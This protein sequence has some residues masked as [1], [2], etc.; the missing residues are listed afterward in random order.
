MRAA[1]R[2]KVTAARLRSAST[3]NKAAIAS[4]A[5]AI[6]RLCAPASSPRRLRCWSPSAGFPAPANR[7]SRARWRPSSGQ[8]PA[9]WCCAPTSSA[10]RCSAGTSTRSCPQDAYA[11]AVTAR[12][13]ATIVDKARRAVAAGHAPIVDARVREAGGA[14]RWWSSPPR[15]AGRSLSRPFPRRRPRH[16]PRA[17]RR[18]RAATPPTPTRR[19]RAQQESY[20]LGALDWAGVDASGTPEQTLARARGAIE[21]SAGL[22]APHR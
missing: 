11:P 3:G 4:D 5:R 1:I 15:C 19:W 13:Y 18:A 8:R 17:R 16:P 6:F 7:R 21:R 22:R 20:D 10:R 14:A 2:A 12:V 9:R